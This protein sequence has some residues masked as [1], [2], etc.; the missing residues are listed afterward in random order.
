VTCYL[1][2]SSDPYPVRLKQG[3]LLLSGE[4]ATWKPDGRL[5]RRP[6]VPMDREFDTITTRS[7][8]RRESEVVRTGAG[9]KA[10]GLILVP[11]FVVVTCATPALS[12]D[13]VVSPTAEPLVVHFFKMTGDLT[14]AT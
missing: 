8:D 12:V 14:E 7:A 6:S 10:L 3:T 1:R 11:P 2:G 9:G 5:K 4:G 13:F